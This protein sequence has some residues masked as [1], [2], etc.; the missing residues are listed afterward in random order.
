MSVEM[1]K[2]RK[3]SCDNPLMFQWILEGRT[4]TSFSFMMATLGLGTPLRTFNVQDT[5]LS[6]QS[7][8]NVIITL[9]ADCGEERISALIQLAYE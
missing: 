9:K 3:G 8:I 2:A 4:S 5:H 1:A 7:F 6:R